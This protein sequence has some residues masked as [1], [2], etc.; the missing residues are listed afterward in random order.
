M[1]RPI[2]RHAGTTAPVS[3]A[4]A[5]P[6]IAAGLPPRAARAPSAKATALAAERVGIRSRRNVTVRPGTQKHRTPQVARGQVSPHDAG[7][8]RCRHRC[9]GRHTS[10]MTHHG[11]RLISDSEFGCVSDRRS[12]FFD[13]RSSAYPECCGEGSGRRGAPGKRRRALACSGA[14]TLAACRRAAAALASC[15]A[16]ALGCVRRSV[17]AKIAQHDPMFGSFAK[18]A[19]QTT[20]SRGTQ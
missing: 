17:A 18:P 5:E 20:G 4:H 14:R 11:V 10:G 8:S 9:N 2:R 6:P 13:T 7:Y 12:R 1:E 19:P 3:P 16:A 15:R